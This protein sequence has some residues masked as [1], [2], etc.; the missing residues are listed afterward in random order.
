MFSNQDVQ[1][2]ASA[3]VCVKVDPRETQDAMEHKTTRYVP[4][5]VLLR[6]DGERIATLEERDPAGVAETL[7][8]VAAEHAR[9][10]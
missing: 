6:S 8:T 9:D 2:A 3:F 7:R 10:N 1:E 4:E 5:V